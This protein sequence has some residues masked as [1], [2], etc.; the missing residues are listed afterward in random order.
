MV[1]Q[2]QIREL[3]DDIV[4]KFNPEK[5][6][7][8]GSYAYGT[9]TPD[10]DVDLLVILPYEGRRRAK[11]TEIRSAIGARFPLDLLAYPREYVEWRVANEDYFL[12][13]ITTK[14]K[15]LYEAADPRMG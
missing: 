6:I 4:R 7:L 12:R 15:V 8:F 9:P 5:V 3:S 1:T 10:S 14:G 13:E 11:A 2:S